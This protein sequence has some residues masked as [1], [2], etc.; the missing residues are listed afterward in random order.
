MS[1]AQRLELPPFHLQVFA[2]YPPIIQ[3]FLNV[4]GVGNAPIVRPCEFFAVVNLASCRMKVH[5]PR[6]GLC[7]TAFQ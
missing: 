4:I 6:S 1:S 2:V 3:H 5:A 7:Q